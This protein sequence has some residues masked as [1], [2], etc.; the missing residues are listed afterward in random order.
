MR[1]SPSNTATGHRGR[2]PVQWRANVMNPITKLRGLSARRLIL[3]ATVANLGLA[4][5]V[6]GTQFQK[7][8]SPVVPWPPAAEIAGR[9]AGFADLVEKVKPAVISVR[10]KTDA[11]AQMMGFN[12][13]DQPFQ[14]NSPMERFFRRFGM[15]F[16]N[17]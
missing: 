15:P 12:D 6:V 10:V 1:R 17:E 5:V 2:G 11:G 7:P 8:G 3:L 16:D 9:P 14:K 4:T 13:E